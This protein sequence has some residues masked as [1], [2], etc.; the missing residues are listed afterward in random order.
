MLMTASRAWSKQMLHSKRES[1][2]G[3]SCPSCA[4]PL[5]PSSELFAFP[6]DVEAILKKFVNIKKLLN[7][8]F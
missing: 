2:V 8:L 1:E 6:V 7:V 4:D 3:L 5:A